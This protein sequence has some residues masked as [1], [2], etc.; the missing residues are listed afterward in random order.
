M[1]SNEPS[2]KGRLLK[3]HG[4]LYHSIY[5]HYDKTIIGQDH[6]KK[7]MAKVLSEIHQDLSKPSGAL[8]VLF[9]KGPTGVG[10]TE[11]AKQTASLLF[12]NRDWYVSVSCEQ[13]TQSHD[14]SKLYGAPPWYL[15]HWKPTLLAPESLF[16]AW[17]DAYRNNSLHKIAKDRPEMSIIVFDEIEKMHPT[18]VQSLLGLID[19]WKSTL[20]DNTKISLEQ[21]IIIFTSNVGET[22]A[23]DTLKSVGFNASN[24]WHKEKQLQHKQNIF[25]KTFSPEFLGRIDHTIEFES[26]THDFL[27]QT[28]NKYKLELINEVLVLTRGQIL[29]Q[30]DESINTYIN[31]TVD[32]SKGNRNI[33]KTRENNI[34][35]TIGWLIKI[36]KLPYYS[37]P[38]TLTISMNKT[39][40][41]IDAILK[42]DKTKWVIQMT[43]EGKLLS[44]QRPDQRQKEYSSSPHTISAQKNQWILS[45]LGGLH[46][47][48]QNK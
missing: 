18:V 21:T 19:E 2:D 36:N 31:E 38:H 13:Y 44:T 26:L 24:E 45:L 7:L 22:G 12:W 42:H 1:N 43:P 23:R 10:K 25:N 6:V 15:W 37:A 39:T 29:V 5:D 3:S 47:N 11:I 20:A 34:K 27:D 9:F 14:G 4:Q 30:F 35:K 48:A 28:L 33:K 46:K 8:R 17:V 16:K 41:E 40:Q 32:A